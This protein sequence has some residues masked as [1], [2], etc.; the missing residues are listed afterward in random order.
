MI[1]N[2]KALISLMGMKALGETGLRLNGKL[3][4]LL[5]TAELNVIIQGSW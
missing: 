1:A 3:Q 5:K 2:N 4:Y